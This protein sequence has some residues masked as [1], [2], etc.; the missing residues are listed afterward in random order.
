LISSRFADLEKILD[1]MERN[2]GVMLPLWLGGSSPGLLNWIDLE[3]PPAR[4]RGAD[5]EI[6]DKFLIWNGTVPDPENEAASGQD[7]GLTYVCPRGLIHSTQRLVGCRRG[8]ADVLG[9]LVRRLNLFR[10]RLEDVMAGALETGEGFLVETGLTDLRDDERSF[11]GLGAALG[12]WKWSGPP[13]PDAIHLV[14]LL[15]VA[16]SPTV[17]DLS[18]GWS[19]VREE[20]AARYAGTDLVAVIPTQPSS[21]PETGRGLRGLRSLLAGGAERR[22]DLDPVVSRVVELVTGSQGAAFLVLKGVFG[23]GRHEA[24][25]R[26]LMQAGRIRGEFPELTLY[27][28]DQAVAAMVSR[29]FTRQ[30][31]V[32][33]LDVRIPGNDVTRSDNPPPRVSHVDPSSALVVICEAQRFDSETRYRIAETGRG[34]R[35]VMTV[36]PAALAE[37]WEHLFLTTPRA[38]D[39]VDLP[40]QRKAAKKLW[41]EVRELV[42]PEYRAGA[43]LRRLKGEL[44]SDYAANLD[45]CLSRVVHEHQEGKLV[46]PL[47]VTAPMP[48]DLEY[49]GSSIRDRGWLVVLETR[50]EGM[51]LPGVREFLAA[52]TDHITLGGLLD[53]TGTS[54]EGGENAAQNPGQAERPDLLL[55]RLLGPEGSAAWAAWVDS[56]DTSTDPTLREFAELVAPTAWA[57]TFLSRPEGRERILRLLEQYGDEPLSALP[58][59]P[60]WE[61][62]WY[63]MFDDLAATGPVH[64]RP[65]AVLTSAARPLGCSQPGAAYLCLGTESPRQHYESLVRV[66]DT[67]L[68]LYQ[69]KSP[70][71]SESAP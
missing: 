18:P 63:T 29:E 21:R 36:D 4:I 22:D 9:E 59:I 54:L 2:L 38:D 23:S 17:R 13:C 15:T 10:T 71:P 45:Q 55:P 49:L 27:C 56:Q 41:S 12:F 20:A 70:L 61:A 28:P 52:A 42:P 11:L 44:V 24:L 46:T 53:Q 37:P 32:G 14:D 60:L 43:G 66:T 58:T 3:H 26:G 16:G 68:V 5:L 19:L 48:G 7:T 1:L 25:C 65:L 50:L 67:L 30:G 8:S 57:N 39:V 69:E 33:P 47:R 51:L 34:R 62:W 6:L 40:G 64:R 35:L 31:F